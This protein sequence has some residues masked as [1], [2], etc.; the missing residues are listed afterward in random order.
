MK[1]PKLSLRVKV[2]ILFT[3]LYIIWRLLKEKRKGLKGCR[4]FIRLYG[5]KDACEKY[6]KLKLKIKNDAQQ[7]IDDAN[8][9]NFLL[10]AS[11]DLA[12]AGGGFKNLYSIG[13]YFVLQHYG[14]RIE[15]ISGASSG[16]LL[17]YVFLH[18]KIDIN[19]AIDTV[20]LMNFPF[21]WDEV[22]RKYNYVELEPV[23]N[24]ITKTAVEDFGVPPDDTCFVSLAKLEGMTFH[25][26]IVSRYRDAKHLADTLVASMAVPFVITPGNRMTREYE[27]FFVC[28]G[29]VTNNVPISVLKQSQAITGDRRMILKVDCNRIDLGW[30]RFFYNVL[31]C[32]QGHFRD[33]MLKGVRDTLELIKGKKTQH[34]G[35]T[36]IN[37]K[38]Y[39]KR[40]HS[41]QLMPGLEHGRKLSQKLVEM[42]SPTAEKSLNVPA[43]AWAR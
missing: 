26:H 10:P 3:L 9:E 11:I 4:S 6:R 1:L 24:H 7:L 17:G 38:N 29:G 43:N 15:K 20:R 34:K 35:L 2:S 33:L 5:D 30:Y 18:N 31:Y 22:H 42:V 41:Y 28:D 12:V 32:D 39:Q 8:V 37:P 21:V 23:W 13:V 40:G 16:S 25:E 19:E 27:G 36:L 14:I